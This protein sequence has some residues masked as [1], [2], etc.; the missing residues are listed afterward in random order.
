[1]IIASVN[2]CLEKPKMSQR[3]QRK[4][5]CGNGPPRLFFFQQRHVVIDK[6]WSTSLLTQPIEGFK[7]ERMIGPVIICPT[8]LNQ[9]SLLLIFHSEFQSLNDV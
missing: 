7:Q 5:A 2:C 6:W 9:P 1:M 3:P 8:C 4:L